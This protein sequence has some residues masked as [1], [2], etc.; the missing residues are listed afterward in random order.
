MAKFEANY[1]KEYYTT[2]ALKDSDTMGGL[3]SKIQEYKRFQK[4]M[5]RRMDILRKNYGDRPSFVKDYEKAPDVSTFIDK[6][7]KFNESDF[8]K[9]FNSTYKY[10]MNP[11]TEYRGF[12]HQLKE[13]KASLNRLFKYKSK[14]TGKEVIPKIFTNKN[15]WDLYDFLD[16]YYQNHKEQ[17]IPAS[18][19]IVDIYVEA[20]RLNMNLKSLAENMDYWK[21]HYEDMQKLTPIEST[22]P[23]SSSEY[24]KLL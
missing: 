12:V 22:R 19:E 3:G 16:E 21:N 8:A 13:S 11:W 15:I 10:V 6:N 18:D 24:E 2:Q 4:E 17:K 9:T 23:V 1:P 14:R 20:V 5:N 7:G